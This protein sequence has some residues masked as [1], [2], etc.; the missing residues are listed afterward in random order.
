MTLN[1]ALVSDVCHRGLCCKL[2]PKKISKVQEGKGK[3]I[4]IFL[5]QEWT[6]WGRCSRTCGGGEQERQKGGSLQTRDCN[7]NNCPSKCTTRSKYKTVLISYYCDLNCVRTFDFL[8]SLFVDFNSMH[9][10]RE[11][12][13]TQRKILK[14]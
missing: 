14:S 13:K 12:V 4:S 5:T 10:A 6:S 11:K 1:C 7:T 8:E 9:F 3:Q 2:H